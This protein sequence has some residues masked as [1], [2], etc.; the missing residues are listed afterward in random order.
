MISIGAA[1]HKK[2]IKKIDAI[3]INTS[4]A[5]ILVFEGLPV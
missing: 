4:F 1:C 5:R 2:M 3:P